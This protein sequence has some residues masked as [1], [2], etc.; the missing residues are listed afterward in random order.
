MSKIFVPSCFLV[1]IVEFPP[2][3]GL[4][5]S[6]AARRRRGRLDLLADDPMADKGLGVLGTETGAV[7][8]V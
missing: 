2:L 1:S 7:W 5:A 6:V 4:L 8:K 3:A